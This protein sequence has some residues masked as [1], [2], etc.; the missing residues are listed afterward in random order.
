MPKA[1]ISYA[2]DGSYGENLAVEIHQQLKAAGFTVFRD[3]ISLKPGDVWFH[4][5]DAELESSDVMVLVLSEKVRTSVWVPNEVDA[6][7]ELGIP[8]IPVLAEKML[9]PIWI[10]HL[11]VLD[12]CGVVDWA[13]L[14]GAIGHHVD[15]RPSPPSPLSRQAVEGEQEST[16]SLS[17]PISGRGVGGREAPIWSH[18]NGQDQYGR[19]ADLAV[20]NVTQRFRWIE[21][22][23]FWMGSPESEP[24]RDGDETWHQVTLTKGFWLGDTACTQSLWKTVLGSNPAYFKDNAK[25]PVEQVSWDDT[26][27]FIQTFNSMVSGLNAQLPTE[28]QWEYACRAGTNTPFSFGDNITP[29]Q[30]NYNGKY[31][32]ASGKIGLSR[33]KTVPVKS[34]PANAWGLYEMHGNV[35]EWCQDWYEDYP[36]E[37]VTNPEGSQ[38]NSERVVRGGSWLHRSA[39]VRSAIRNMHYPVSLANHRGFRLSLG[40]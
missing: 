5:L 35:W 31:P 28:A 19:Y 1:F 4:K 38:A 29:R 15:G 37:S 21:P 30:V 39:R 27:E 36:E 11:Q 16:V 17:P 7:K 26:Q 32:Y 18:D 6:A 40:L 13:L 24:E 25:N 33:Q 9:R 20:K 2:R 34:F 12:F 14:F 23:T 10:R 8:I 3:V 22:G